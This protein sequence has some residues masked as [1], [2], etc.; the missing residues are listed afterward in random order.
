ME[1]Q[2]ARADLLELAIQHSPAPMGILEGPEYIL[3]LYNQAAAETTGVR[4]ADAIGKPAAEAF[5]EAMAQIRPFLDRAYAGERVEF[6]AELQ[7]PSGMRHVRLTYIPLPGVPTRILYVAVDETPVHAANLELR[8]RIEHQE[9]TARELRESEERFRAM[10]DSIPQLAWMAEPDGYI[11]WYN[12]RW[13]EYTGTTP[14]QMRGWGWQSV[15]D[16]AVLPTVI[17]RWKGSI[18]SG[19]PFDMEFPLRGANG[20]FRWFLTRVQP[21]KGSDGRVLRWFGTNTDV[22]ET[23]EL[24]AQRTRELRETVAEYESFAYSVAHDL[25]AP[26]RTIH[27]FGQI[28]MGDLS[29]RIPEDARRLLEKILSAAQRMDRLVT[30]LLVYSRLGREPIELAPVALEGVVDQVVSALGPELTERAAEVEIVRP[31]P[32]VMGQTTLLHQAVTNLVANAAK[33]MPAGRA[34]RIMIRTERLADRVRLSVEDN[35]IGI[36]AE[37]R[38]KIFNVFQRLHG[39]SEYE[40]TGIGLAIVRRSAERLGGSVGVE[41]EPGKGSRFWIDLKAAPESGGGFPK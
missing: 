26:L 34:P 30:D 6:S 16:P 18:A 13:Y 29:L 41:S 37:Y 27:G 11:F 10:A 14:E 7:L 21:L 3:R 20:K 31:M 36:P 23:V 19:R 15:H 39:Q 28:L 4:V 5:P 33:F 12:R 25:R 8:R 1:R 24:I 17:Q 40:G 32:V 22:N 35:G 9:A 38:E 2:A